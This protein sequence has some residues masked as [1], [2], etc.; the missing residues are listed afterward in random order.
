MAAAGSKGEGDV[1]LDAAG[2]SEDRAGPAVPRG[3]SWGEG[4]LDTPACRSWLRS[5]RKGVPQ[6]GASSQEQ[7]VVEQGRIRPGQS[8]PPAQGNRISAALLAMCVGP[9]VSRKHGQRGVSG[10]PPPAP[11][12]AWFGQPAL[13]RGKG[14]REREKPQSCEGVLPTTGA[15]VSRTAPPMHLGL[16]LLCF[17][18]SLSASLPV[19]ASV[20]FSGCTAHQSFLVLC[21][22]CP[23]PHHLL[24]VL[25]IPLLFWLHTCYYFFLPYY[26]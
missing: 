4:C 22:H 6:A 7:R 15:A 3:S 9:R 23:A 2:E 5:D 14:Q 12:G 26:L 13:W 1:L 16:S 10:H 11:G 24:S 20:S 18:Q 21:Q 25:S 8:T 19:P 17:S